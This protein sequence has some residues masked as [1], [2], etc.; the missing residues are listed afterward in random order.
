MR[1]L[2]RFDGIKVI[3]FVS[4]AIEIERVTGWIP[5]EK[6]DISTG[7]IHASLRSTLSLNILFI[8]AYFDWRVATLQGV[9]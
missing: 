5:A 7:Q 2:N 4:S 8:I 3:P 9:N 6:G 1:R